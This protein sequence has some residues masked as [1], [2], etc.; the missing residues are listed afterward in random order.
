MKF[1]TTNSTTDQLPTLLAAPLA[2]AL[3]L[4]GCASPS[5]PSAAVPSDF[6]VFIQA[7]TSPPPALVDD[8]GG[9]DTLPEY[10]P[11]LYKL[12]LGTGT[13]PEEDKEQFLLCMFYEAPGDVAICKASIPV[14]W[15]ELD[16]QHQQANRVL[17]NQDED[18]GDLDVHADSED[19]ATTR[20][21]P[22][23]ITEEAVIVGIHIRVEDNEAYFSTEPDQLIGSVLITPDS[24]EVLTETSPAAPPA[25]PDGPRDLTPHAAKVKAT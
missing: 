11:G 1:P 14:R 22:T 10:G 20:I 3:A 24:Y 12:D 9:V 18:T 19:M 23:D 16:G 2:L 6:P 8:H 17:I 21:I 4:T 13:G 7:A 15:K 25:A 5:T